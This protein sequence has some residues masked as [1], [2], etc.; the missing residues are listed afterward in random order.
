M[1]PESEFESRQPLIDAVLRDDDW[2]TASAALKAE[3]LKT[4]HARQRVRRLTRWAIGA[5]AMIVA[6]EITVHWFAKPDRFATRVARQTPPASKSTNGPAQLTDE[7]LLA[8]F[9]KGSCF[10]ADVGGHKELVFYSREVE[11][12][13]VVYPTGPLT[14]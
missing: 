5:A 3:A 10:L 1:K 2:Q 7:Q 11:H 13:Y 9:P 12:T 8:S 14:R 4:L 6:V